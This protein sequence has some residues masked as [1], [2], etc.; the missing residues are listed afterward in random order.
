M[1]PLDQFLHGG[2]GD[3]EAVDPLLGPAG[4]EAEPTRDVGVLWALLN[5]CLLYTSD[6]AD[7]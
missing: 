3:A 6:A 7:E 1:L 2:L 5:D 4:E